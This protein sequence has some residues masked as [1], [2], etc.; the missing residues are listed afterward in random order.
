[1][2]VSISTIR[3]WFRNGL[4][5]TQTQFWS[6]WDSFW[7]KD[8]KISIENI[9]GLEEIIDAKI[10]EALSLIHQFAP[11]INS[12]TPSSALPSTTLQVTILGEFFNP[13]TTFDFVGQ[14]VD[15]IEFISTNE[16]RVTITTSPLDLVESDI[17]ADNGMQSTFKN[18]FISSVGTVMTPLASDFTNVSGDITITDGNVR[19]ASSTAV[20]RARWNKLV[21]SANSWTLRFTL[22]DSGFNAASSDQLRFYDAS[23]NLISDYITFDYNNNPSTVRINYRI[24]GNNFYLEHFMPRNSVFS[25]RV[26]A[27]GE[28]QFLQDGTITDTNTNRLTSDFRFNFQVGTSDFEAI[29]FLSQ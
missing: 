1:M 19:S 8:E 14:N 2:A 5:P 20:G 22:K 16:M 18:V 21:D 13:D 29:R 4:R 26:N 9:D 6:T 24:P 3:D 12:V 25:L 11:T 7:H 10:E 27:L 17:I 28:I 15:L 23:G